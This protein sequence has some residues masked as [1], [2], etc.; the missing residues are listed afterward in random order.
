MRLV[1][2]LAHKTTLRLKFR[3]AFTRVEAVFFYIAAY[4]V[5]KPQGDSG[6]EACGRGNGVIE[7]AI[8]GPF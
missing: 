1:L 5:F 4:A 7:A 3:T 6:G 2:F 8:Y